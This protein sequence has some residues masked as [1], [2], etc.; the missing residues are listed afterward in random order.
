MDGWVIIGTDLDTKTFDKRL[1][2][3]ESKL[4]NQELDFEIKTSS[5]E[6]AKNELK[7][8]GNEAQEATKKQKQLSE[9]I[10]SI[11][12]EHDKIEKKIFSGQAIQPAEY[13]KRQKLEEDLVPLKKELEEVTKEVDK[14]NRKINNANDNL[15]KMTNQ[16]NKQQEKIRD[17][18]NDI[19]QV[20]N[21]IKKNTLQDTENKLKSIS[22]STGNI[23]KKIARWGLAIFS[24]RSAYNFI[25]QS[26]NTLSQYNEKLATDIE[27]IRY[28]LASSLQ[29]IIE[30]I[31]Q[32]MYKM[33]AYINYISQAWFG[34]NIFANASVKSFE[35][36]R[37][38]LGG[39]NKQAKE[40]QKTLAGFDEMNILQDGSTTTGGGGGGIT[41]PSYDLGKMEDVP[42][43]SWIKW[44]AENGPTV[45]LIL[46]SIGAALLGIKLAPF[47]SG[48]LGVT[49][50]LAKFKMGVSLVLGGLVLLVTEIVNLVLNW[51][52]LDGKQ[53]AL[54]IG[55]ASLGAA[56]VALGLTI[57]GLSGGL[58]LLITGLT[59][60]AT[61]LVT[62]IIKNDEDA[63]S[64]LSVKDATNQLK[65][66][67]E[68]LRQS[69]N[70]YTSAVDNAK[71]SSDDL[72]KA[73]KELQKATGD[74]TLTGEK[75]FASVLAGTK[76]V[77]NMTTAE[78]KVYKAYLNNQ[79]AQKE[80]TESNKE[81][82]DYRKESI[83]KAEQEAAAIYKSTGKYNEYFQAVID[84]YNKKTVT[85]SQMLSAT[86]KIYSK[87]D[88]ETQKIFA[89]S[90]PENIKQAF[91]KSG[92][93]VEQFDKNTKVSYKEIA[94]NSRKTFEKD[95]PNSLSKTNTALDKT[96]NKV[97]TLN[98]ALGGGGNLS[99]GGGSISGGGS[100]NAKG[101]VYYPPKLAVG[102]IINQPGRG[103]P[104]AVGGERGAEGVI[105]LTDSQ[106]MQ[107]LG[108][109][110]G[111]N[112]VINA[113]LNNYMNS[114][115]M[116]REML[117]TENITD[118]AFNR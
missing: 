62:L 53:K 65:D 99:F 73:E 100:R 23:V 108:E 2:K 40:L 106:M 67:Q 113:I 54:A 24:V 64:T 28:S 90:L 118:F 13:L 38:S 84:G 107:Q 104:L 18:R 9:Q 57:T 63:K 78:L 43:P 37:K 83:D 41:L 110:I 35:K 25:R 3:L 48:I 87:L 109:A 16:Y 82:N 32:L 61:A 55:I 56:L 29:P 8:L 14:Y 47:L 42:I 69:T 72:K 58:S 116:N 98:K 4:K 114:R 91:E 27:Y 71:K 111:R 6:K 17:T 31:I 117:K 33:L 50:G 39:S 70:R 76:T 112:V 46:G 86:S 59:A 44:I 11:Q 52:Q 101:A 12:K 75:L 60:L 93:I 10:L 19:A 5:L 68:K 1:S 96:I 79:S 85:E 92:N 22:T 95:V 102:G 51:D 74:H 103:V 77:D 30:N 97:N 88:E 7:A 115:L 66:A 105:P 45:A 34:I 49:E 89:Q 20:N 36:A 15:V 26:V 80:L 94:D 21:E 81:M